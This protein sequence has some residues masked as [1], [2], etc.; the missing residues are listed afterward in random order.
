MR[1]QKPSLKNIH[2]FW[3][4]V[5]KGEVTSDARTEAVRHAMLE[6]TPVGGPEDPHSDVFRRTRHAP[7]AR[8]LWYL[9]SDLMAAISADRGEAVARQEISVIA[10]LFDGL[11]PEARAPIT[12]RSKGKRKRL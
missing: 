2:S 9:R 1:W 4:Q 7:N 3:G 11:I 6:A 8:A 5:A 10:R 12:S